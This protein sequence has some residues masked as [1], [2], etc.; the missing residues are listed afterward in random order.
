MQNNYTIKPWDSV[1]V[2]HEWHNTEIPKETVI[3]SSNDLNYSYID[4]ALLCVFMYN[5]IVIIFLFFFNKNK[6]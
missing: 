3:N 4:L 6:T 5:I 1:N 2:Y